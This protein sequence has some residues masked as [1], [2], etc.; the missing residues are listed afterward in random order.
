VSETARE[1]DGSTPRPS[2]AELFLAF[3]RLSLL[4]FGGPQA[5]LALML[6]DVVERRRWITREHFL[7][8]V[9]VTNLI[10]GPNSSEVAIHIGYTQRGYSGAL[11][12][13]LAFL[14]PTFLIVLVLSWLYFGYG[15]LPSA[16]ALLWGIK[17]AVLAV[18]VWA[19]VR[20]GREALKDP[21]TIVLALVGMVVA[22]RAGSWSALAMAVG[23][24]ATW[25]RWRARNP[26]EAPLDPRL[27]QAALIPLLP[28]AALAAPGALATVFLVH[29]A[30]GSV[31]F[32]G[33]YVLVALLQP[34]AVERFAWLSASAFL[35]GVALTQAVP[36]P[37]STL[38][39]F[40][41]YAAAG[42]PG[43]ILATAGIYLP[44]FAAVLLIA[45]H[46]ERSRETEPVKAAL[47]GV[48]AVVAGAIVGVAA[49]LM[50][51]ALPDVSAVAVFA[52]ALVAVAYFGVASV[53]VVLA[54]LVTGLIRLT[55]G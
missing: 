36:G 7:Q 39:A 14:V 12:A 2:L 17:P 16:E 54:G 49:G 21:L 29:L 18:I 13:G 43:A 23:G 32:G 55:I 53:W 31:L 34:Y 46:L 45:P 22:W 52:L 15:A 33:G 28:L 19:G 38:A 5:H 51:A 40:V 26:P 10:P 30:I 27:P 42:V 9:G 24:V 3:L 8:L 41:G 35:D 47:A 25:A 37:I 4:G 20:L 48:S 11:V 44:A 50:P 1:G 6:D